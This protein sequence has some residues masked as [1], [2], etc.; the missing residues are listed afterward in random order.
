MYWPLR[1][2]STGSV[3]PPSSELFGRRAVIGVSVR[4][5]RARSCSR[6]L[7]LAAEGADVDVHRDALVEAAVVRVD[8]ALRSFVATSQ[9]KPMRGA[10]LFFRLNDALPI[11]VADVL[12]F[13]ADAGVDREFGA[14]L[15]RVLRVERRVDRVRLGR[16]RQGDLPGRSDRPGRIPA[17]DRSRSSGGGSRSIPVARPCSL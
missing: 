15:Q 16:Q 5:A 8:L 10:Q 4:R 11:A 9:M 2:G 1:F 14:G 17:R 13:P 12:P 7:Q 3:L 6:S